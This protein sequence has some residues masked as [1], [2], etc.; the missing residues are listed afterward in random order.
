MMAR[1]SA[2]R[3]AQQ[4]EEFRQ[5][6]LKEQAIL[7]PVTQAKAEA[8]KLSAVAS[9][10]NATRIQNLRGQAAAVSKTAN[11]EFLDAMQLA[12]FNAK[13]T[14]LAGL[15]AKYQWMDLI[16]EY[17]GFVDTINDERLKAHGSA[18]ADATM[19]RQ[20]AAE[21][22]RYNRALDVAN[23]T[24]GARRD[25]AE[26]NAGSREQVATTNAGSHQAVAETNAGARANAVQ[27]SMARTEVRGDLQSAIEADKEAARFS[28]AGD[29]TAAAEARGRAQAFRDAAKAKATPPSSAA[30]AP[31]NVPNVTSQPQKLYNPPA[32][33]GGTI[34]FSPAVKT[35]EQIIEGLQ[36]AV[37]DGQITADEA[38]ETLKKLGFKPKQ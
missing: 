33:E 12:D 38:R 21:D 25:V 34:T 19:E 32:Q 20:L 30:G 16:P 11:D 2:L 29:E 9:I 13:A 10:A 37:N 4:M 8:D 23:V 27:G 5:N 6:Q 15:Q 28:Q 22:I 31:F 36:Q 7:M 26:T 3:Q 18:I 14:A 24:A 35:P 17:K 1:A